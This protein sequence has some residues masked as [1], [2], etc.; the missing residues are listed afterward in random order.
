[1][2]AF[3]EHKA[4][5]KFLRLSRQ[6]C[7]S[8]YRV[9]FRGLCITYQIDRMSAKCVVIADPSKVASTSRYMQHEGAHKR[10]TC[11]SST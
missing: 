4:T 1:M 10:H 11:D 2:Y 7:T 8:Q 3:G 9:L 5:Y 6:A